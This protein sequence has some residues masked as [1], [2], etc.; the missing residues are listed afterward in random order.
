MNPNDKNQKPQQT[1]GQDMLQGIHFVPSTES[2]KNAPT[3]ERAA[4]EKE[5]LQQQK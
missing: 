2:E 5:R 1:D 4:E 3:P